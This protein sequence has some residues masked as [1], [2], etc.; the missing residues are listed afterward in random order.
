LEIRDINLTGKRDLV[1]DVAL[2]D[3]F[4]GN[5]FAIHDAIGN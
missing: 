1:I 4:S 2:I 5:I 3:D